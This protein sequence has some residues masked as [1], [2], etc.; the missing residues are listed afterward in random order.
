MEQPEI[1]IDEIEI[2]THFLHYLLKNKIYD[3]K[4][5]KNNNNSYNIKFKIYTL[6]REIAGTCSIYCLYNK[7]IFN[8]KTIQKES[9]QK[10]KIK[11]QINVLRIINNEIINEEKTN[12]KWQSNKKTILEN[13]TDNTEIIAN[14]TPQILLNYIKKRIR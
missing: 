4:I 3:I 9:N 14:K 2:I 11:E 6:D 1:T 13:S 5:T 10:E 12:V 7:I 8:S